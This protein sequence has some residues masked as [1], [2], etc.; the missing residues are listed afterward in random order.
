MYHVGSSRTYLSYVYINDKRSLIIEEYSYSSNVNVL[1]S[2]KSA[3]AQND[4]STSLARIKARV[5][6]RG[7]SNDI[8][9][10]CEVN[11][12]SNALDMA[13]RDLGL[14]S[15]R[16]RMLPLCG[17]GTERALMRPVCVLL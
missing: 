4:A 12:A 13:F 17:A 8:S 7:P 16:I 3:P 6:P 5:D 2:F 1:L 10:I 15:D 9:L 14:L 11:S